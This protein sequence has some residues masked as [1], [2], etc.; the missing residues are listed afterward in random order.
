VF[1]ITLPFLYLFAAAGFAGSR[2]RHD[3]GYAGQ[4]RVGA[5]L[6]AVVSIAIH[7]SILFESLTRGGGIHVSLLSS[8]SLIGLQ[9]AVIGTLAA[10][11][12]DLRGVAAGLL[13]LAAP[14]A[15][16]TQTGAV[17]VTGSGLSWQLQTHVFT[18]MFAYGLL[19][20]GAIVAI[21]ALI[22]DHRLRAAKLS[23]VN[24]LFAPL[25][26]TERV[27]YGVASAGI[28]VLAMS[29]ALG[30]TFVENLFAQHLVHKTV[31]SLIALTVFGILLAGRHFAGWRGKRAIYL[32]LGGFVLLF[33]AYFGSRYI[34]E[35]VLHRSW[36]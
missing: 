17:E 8:V 25:E 32:Y 9:L 13:V 23:S 10:I 30:I 14:T 35:V 33:L 11:D 6:L 27:L 2:L 3:T 22:Q 21:Y 34:L 1:Q 26:K 7:A 29:M 24:L 28:A 18:A 4:L 5:F 16:A 36:G 19:A 15:L 12:T 20:A 31:L